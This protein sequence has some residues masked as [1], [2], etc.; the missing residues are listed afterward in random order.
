MPTWEHFLREGSLCL[1]CDIMSMLYVTVCGRTNICIIIA[2]FG[3]GSVFKLG[4]N[5]NWTYQMCSGTF[6]PSFAYKAE[7]ELVFSSV[8]ANFVKEPD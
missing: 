7:C 3:T 5:A 6:G 2:D 1:P 8:F 4:S